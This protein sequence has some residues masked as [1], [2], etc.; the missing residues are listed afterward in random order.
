MLLLLTSVICLSVSIY[1]QMSVL[2]YAYTSAS[3]QFS[4]SAELRWQSRSLY[5][6]LCFYNC[7]HAPLTL[8]LSFSDPVSLALSVSLSLSLSLCMLLCL[9]ICLCVSLHVCVPSSWI[10]ASNH[11]LVPLLLPVN[12]PL[13]RCAI[14]MSWSL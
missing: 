2:L 3:C 11:C 9:C 12:Y 4:N 10:L 5:S 13:C 1:V 7:L 8:F 6:C 14:S